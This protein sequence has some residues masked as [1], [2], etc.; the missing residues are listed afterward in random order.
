M[1][2]I[3]T[4]KTK[5]SKIIY[6][7]E[8]HRGWAWG[9]GNWAGGL[10]NFTSCLIIALNT[11]RLWGPALSTCPHTNYAD[12]L[13][14]SCPEHQILTLH[15]NLWVYLLGSGADFIPFQSPSHHHHRCHYQVDTLS[16][17]STVQSVASQLWEPIWT[18]NRF[19]LR[20][21]APKRWLMSPL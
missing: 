14:I 16:E 12:G 15:P 19:L 6:M 1:K 13:A 17:R 8:V 7:W 2:K 4:G 10:L 11:R 9:W 18:T 5:G 21:V 20:N 3:E